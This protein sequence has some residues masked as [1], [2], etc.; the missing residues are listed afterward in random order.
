[1]TQIQNSSSSPA[2]IGGDWGL[3]GHY[4]SSEFTIDSRGVGIA[5]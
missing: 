4:K 1:M 2:A 3:G 5:A